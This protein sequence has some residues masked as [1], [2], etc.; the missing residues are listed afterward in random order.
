MKTVQLWAVLIGLLKWCV[1]FDIADNRVHCSNSDRV[2]DNN[3]PPEISSNTNTSSAFRSPPFSASK[4][5]AGKSHNMKRLSSVVYKQRQP[6]AHH[7]ERNQTHH[8]SK[9]PWIRPINRNFNPSSFRPAAAA[10]SGLPSP[11][12]SLLNP[13]DGH[14]DD[15]L[16][17]NSAHP[18]RPL[19]AR[20][21][22]KVFQNP[23][24]ESHHNKQ[25]VIPSL[26]IPDTDAERI[27]VIGMLPPD[28]I[29]QDQQ[30]R[31]GIDDGQHQ[32]QEI[33]IQRKPS[34]YNHKFQQQN[35]QQHPGQFTRMP[36]EKPVIIPQPGAPSL[37]SDVQSVVPTDPNHFGV[38]EKL[39][40]RMEVN[41]DNQQQSSLV[42][43]QQQNP[44]VPPKPQTS[45]SVEPV[46]FEN[47][48]PITEIPMISVNDLLVTA[49]PTEVVPPEQEKCEPILSS[50]SNNM[51]SVTPMVPNNSPNNEPVGPSSVQSFSSKKSL[52]FLR[53]ANFGGS[54]VHLGNLK[55]VEDHP[56]MHF[57]SAEEIQ[58]SPAEINNETVK[59]ETNKSTAT[60]SGIPEVIPPGIWIDKQDGKG[61]KPMIKA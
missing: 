11:T 8:L 12:Q 14:E 43:Q 17:E 21:L 51:V 57:E 26:R 34:S 27:P 18:K 44:A 10:A 16:C 30:T 45:A 33:T 28:V 53:R 60:E 56:E 46:V 54:S 48:S 47:P 5:L 55:V 7:H 24:A 20:P 49:V 41:N 39:H 3:N 4:W 32:H 37:N 22:Q 9:R 59:V 15:V 13:E 25:H 2:L 40:P 29:A 1:I 38:H 31:P 52:K 58:R 61:L 19:F 35:H 42:D 6:V 36:Q 23:A 50:G